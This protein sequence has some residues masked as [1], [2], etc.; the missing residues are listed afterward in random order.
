[1]PF[2]LKGMFVDER[3][4]KRIYRI[5]VAIGVILFVLI[6]YRLFTSKLFQKEAVEEVYL[7]PVT[8]TEVMTGDIRNTLFYSGDIQGEE[9]AIVYSVVTGTLLRYTVEEGERV[10]KGETLALLRRLETWEEYKPVV[11]ES[12]ISGIVG[13]NYLDIGEIATS[14]TPIS[15]VVGGKGL[16]VTMKVPD[17][18]LGM[19]DVGMPA[20]VSVPTIPDTWFV[21][22]VSKVSPIL[23]ADTRT[24]YV[25]VFLEERPEQVWPGMFGDVHIIIEEKSD[26]TI[27]PAEVIMYAG[28]EMTDPYCFVLDDN[29]THKRELELG[30]TEG[31]KVEIL[32]GVSPGELA[33]D[34]GKENVDDGVEVEVI[35]KESASE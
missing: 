2:L 6:I 22:E 26:V 10:R 23:N 3:M 7:V 29:I 16:R 12:P 27:V 25:E 15:L 28:N 9:Q 5:A 19:I 1:M 11:V 24:A 34:L 17:I 18:E 4:K 30:I 31:E 35:V 21:G 8:T 14:Q 13:Y 20:E 33:I 32:S